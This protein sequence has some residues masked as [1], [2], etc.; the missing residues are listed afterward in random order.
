MGAA[1]FLGV[2]SRQC[3]T[4]Q[5]VLALSSG[6]AEYHSAF[7]GASV[8]LGFKPMH[9]DLGEDMCFRLTHVVQ[10]FLELSGE[11]VSVK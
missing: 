9:A 6:E 5:A 2:S 8:A 11:E 1:C 7:T 3:W 10:P 4:F